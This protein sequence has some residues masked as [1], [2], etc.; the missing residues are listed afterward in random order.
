MDGVA[1]FRGQGRWQN[2]GYL[3]RPGD[4]IFFDWNGNVTL[5]HVGIVEKVEGKVIYIIEG[6]FTEVSCRQ[7][8]YSLEGYPIYG[9]GTTA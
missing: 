4:V 1:W 3:P 6:S 5:N 7:N 9:Y 2:S 8:R